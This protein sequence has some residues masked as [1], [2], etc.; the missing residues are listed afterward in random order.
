MEYYLTIKRNEVLIHIQHGPWKHYAKERCQ[1][2]KTVYHMT[3]INM[4]CPEQ[5]NQ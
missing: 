2:Q 4:K 3:I 5:A 1:A